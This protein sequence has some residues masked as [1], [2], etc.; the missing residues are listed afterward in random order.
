M[1]FLL[2]LRRCVGLDNLNIY[3]DSFEKQLCAFWYQQLV[4]INYSWYQQL[5]LINYS[6]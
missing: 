3:K 4:L 5:V 6:Y 1:T 2:I